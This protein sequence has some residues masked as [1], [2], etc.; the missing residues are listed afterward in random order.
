[1]TALLVIVLQ[2]KGSEFDPRQACELGPR[3]KEKKSP[4][5]WINPGKASRTLG[6]R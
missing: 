1:M 3:K 6:H 4:G 2:T 5:E